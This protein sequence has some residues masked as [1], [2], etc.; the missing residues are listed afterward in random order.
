MLRD[1]TPEILDKAPYIW[2]PTPYVY[3]AWWPWV[4]NYGASCAPAPCGPARSTPASGSTR[5]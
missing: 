1:M 3:T 4:K 5:S 2:L